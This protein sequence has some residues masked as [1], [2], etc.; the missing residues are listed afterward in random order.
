[1]KQPGGHE[2]QGNYQN[3]QE[4]GLQDDGQMERREKQTRTRRWG[5]DIW[6]P[7]VIPGDVWYYLRNIKGRGFDCFWR[8]RGSCSWR[9]STLNHWCVRFLTTKINTDVLQVQADLDWPQMRT[10]MIFSVRYASLFEPLC[11]MLSEGNPRVTHS[12]EPG[13]IPTGANGCGAASYHGSSYL[14]VHSQITFLTSEKENTS[15]CRT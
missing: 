9:S 15:L 1:M 2:R 11:L 10:E 8:I 12:L 5:G 14:S 13:G 4:D 3:R 6:S 7:W